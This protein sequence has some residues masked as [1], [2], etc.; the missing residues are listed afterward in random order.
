MRGIRAR[1]AAGLRGADADGGEPAPVNCAK[2][3]PLRAWNIRGGIPRPSALR[4]VCPQK[5]PFPAGLA[6]APRPGPDIP[7][8]GGGDRGGKCRNPPR[9]FFPAHQEKHNEKV[10]LFGA[11]KWMAPPLARAGRGARGRIPRRIRPNPP[12]ADGRAENR[13]PRAPV[14]D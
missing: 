4:P 3:A 13:F 1:A 9:P 11:G 10:A 6:D 14:R 5:S 7:P 2:N 12:N 8:P